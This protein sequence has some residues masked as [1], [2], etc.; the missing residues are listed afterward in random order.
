MEWGSECSRTAWLSHLVCL[1]LPHPASPWQAYPEHQ[2]AKKSKKGTPCGR[3]RSHYSIL[4]SCKQILTTWALYQLTAVSIT[5]STKNKANL[6]GSLLGLWLWEASLQGGWEWLVVAA[7]TSHAF[8]SCESQSQQKLRVFP[9]GP[10][11]NLPWMQQTPVGSLVW[12]LRFPH[13]AEQLSPCTP[14]RESM[15]RNERSNM[16]QQRTSVL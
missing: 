8:G 10:V 16:T 7:H 12:V 5:K 3:P 6:D 2:P 1:P 11:K 4:L 15:N 14:T 13:A 9:G